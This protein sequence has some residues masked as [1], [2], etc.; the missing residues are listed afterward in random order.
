MTIPLSQVFLINLKKVICINSLIL[1]KLSA[2]PKLFVDFF[3]EFLYK[4]IVL[5]TESLIFA[6]LNDARFRI[7]LNKYCLILRPKMQLLR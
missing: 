3:T 2:I 5:L 6:L 1:Q 7:Y 4:Y